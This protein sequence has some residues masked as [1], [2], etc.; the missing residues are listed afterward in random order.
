MA[1]FES[2]RPSPS[3]ALRG[4][5][6]GLL[7][8]AAALGLL[9]ALGR[10]DAPPRARPGSTPAR[11]GAFGEPR[12][13][14]EPRALHH[15]RAR[16]RGRG[17]DA[18]GPEKIPAQG[19]KDILWRTYEEMQRDRLLAVAAGVAF[20]ALLAI[21]PAV[22]ALVSL[23]G[24]IFEPSTVM[25]HLSA[26]GA[27]LPPGGFDIVRDQVDR[28]VSTAGAGLTLGFLGGLGIALWSANNGVKAVFDALN[29]IY[30][31]D[32]KRGFVKLNLVSLTFTLGGIL[33]FL[34]FVGVIAVLP[35]VFAQIG[36]AGA[37]EWLLPFL[38]WPALFVVLL[39]ALALIYRF[40]PSRTRP[41]WRWISVGSLFATVT[42]IVMSLLF[43]W[44]LQNFANYNAIYGSLGAVI[45]MMMWMWLS[46]VVVLIGG[47]LNAETEHQTARDTTIA[48]DKP[49]GARGAAM[50]DNVGAAK[51]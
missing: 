7:A 4:L 41:Q 37:W 44:Y 26:V 27:M 47:E 49:L 9:S 22:T 17:R 1:T 48:G 50:A 19:W 45:G 12:S 6:W 18:T 38:R 29:V 15:A 43:S 40:G 33:L 46:A 51:K 13:S 42:W 39:L 10:R 32:E 28:V 24:L 21:F 23:Y 36:L 31:E 20:Y 30:D 14:D 25:G 16:E 2:S 34:T 11:T 5:P 3:R 8:S 35:I